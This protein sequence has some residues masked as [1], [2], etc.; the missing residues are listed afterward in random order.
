MAIC[1]KGANDED[2]QNCREGERD[3]LR[4]CLF[5]F[6][7]VSLEGDAA[8]KGTTV[9]VCARMVALA[10][11]AM[12]RLP[13][14]SRDDMGTVVADLW[15]KAQGMTDSQLADRIL[16]K[17]NAWQPKSPQGSLPRD[18]VYRTVTE[19][20]MARGERLVSPPVE[21]EEEEEDMVVSPPIAARGGGGGGGGSGG[22][23]RAAASESSPTRT[24]A[25]RPRCAV[26]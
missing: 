13:F 4:R 3:T 21:E 7:A 6:R 5:N 17:L 9:E 19:G 1:A 2:Q 10:I 8:E 24:R 22:R 14:A 18:H 23:G 15:F 25:G 12:L 20:H 26:W 16:C 11:K